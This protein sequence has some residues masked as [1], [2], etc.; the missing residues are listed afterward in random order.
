MAAA[1]HQKRLI[2]SLRRSVAGLSQRR[3]LY[4]L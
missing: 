2:V 4:V 3:S 1:T